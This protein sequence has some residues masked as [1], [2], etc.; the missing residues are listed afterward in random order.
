MRLEK[1]TLAL[2][3]ALERYQVKAE[4]IL[5][6]VVRR[7]LTRIQREHLPRR[8]FQFMDA[9]GRIIIRV[10]GHC[11]LDLICR[12]QGRLPDPLV[13]LEHLRGWYITHSE[14]LCISDIV[15]EPLR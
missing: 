1:D 11:T 4:K 15:L 14:R 7:E 3:R 5:E 9:M 8:K 13:E 10:D 6:E 2:E 12:Y